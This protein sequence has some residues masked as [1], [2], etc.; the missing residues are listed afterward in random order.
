ME[1][2]TAAGKIKFVKDVFVIS[3]E[4]DEYLVN[5]LKSTF[6]AR[7]FNPNTKNWL[8]PARLFNEIKQFAEEYGFELDNINFE[9]I[10]QT[11]KEKLEK[12][13][14]LNADIS[15]PAPSGLEYLPYQK[16]GIAYIADKDHVLVAD[17]M[18][19]GKTIQ[20]IGYI[21]LS[22]PATVL[23]VCPS[24]LMKN[25]K[26]ELQKWLVFDA[27]INIAKTSKQTIKINSEKSSISILSYDSVS[28]H[29]E[30]SNI[31]FDCAIFDESHYL[32]N[33][34]A[35]RTKASLAIKA[36]KRIFLTGTPI[37]NRPIEL[38]PILNK[39]GIFQNWQYFEKHFCA[40]RQTKY[41]WDV[42]G[43]SNLNE[44]QTI[45]REKV[46]IRRLKKDVLTEL[47]EKRR[48]NLILEAEST[49]EKQAIKQEMKAFD[50]YKKLKKALSEAK[51]EEQKQVLRTGIG[52]AFQEIS[53]LRKLTAIA[54][55]PRIAAI[56]R[57]ML[58]NGEVKKLVIFGHHHEVI[59]KIFEELKEF[60]VLVLD[61]R[62]SQEKR[63]SIVEQF[64]N[65]DN[66][67]VF[68]GGIKA[69]G[70]GFTLTAAS[71]CLFAE[72]DW[73][74]A[75]LLQAEDRLHRIGQKNAVLSIYPLLESSLDA[76]IYEKLFAKSM[77]A[78]KALDE[79]TNEQSLFEQVF[80]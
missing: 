11:I 7:T 50:D 63:Q 69:A 77:I 59:D 28:K 21:N 9:E 65:N 13:T 40:G 75:G 22:K 19:L 14:A 20:A 53:K 27:E 12:S 76:T 47:P 48:Q 55:A 39:I 41:G 32:K 80:E 44:L 35:K 34:A 66:A 33:Y 56:A 70:V 5:A 64:Q 31:F 23:V 18:G 78:S 62:T 36:K 17:E 37:L 68:V 46:M 24:S 4:F 2:A 54:K 42:G 67:K 3:F 71:V 10:E 73:T 26:N 45:L 57:E 8:V 61:G 51:T 74:P 58:E 38:Y 15:I 16:A 49:E 6:S 25:W 30:L 60:G 43:A 52:A 72:L 1:T 29:N 79:T